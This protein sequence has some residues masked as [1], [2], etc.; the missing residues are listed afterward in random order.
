MNESGLIQGRRGGKHNNYRNLD[1]VRRLG[2]SFGQEELRNVL[3]SHLCDPVDA[4]STRYRTLTLVAKSQSACVSSDVSS[5]SSR[6]LRVASDGPYSIRS[7]SNI[8][9]PPV[10]LPYL[11]LPDVIYAERRLATLTALLVF[12]L[13]KRVSRFQLLCF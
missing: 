10:G 11:H 8:R 6:P 1:S 4:P 9:F 13:L 12:E 3:A 5:A 2:Q 7:H